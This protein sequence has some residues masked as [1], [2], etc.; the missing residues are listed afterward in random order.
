[1]KLPWWAYRLKLRLKWLLVRRSE[2]INQITEVEIYLLDCS[3]GK[4]PQPTRAVC[5]ILSLRLGTPK[6]YWSEY[7]KDAALAAAEAPQ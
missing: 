6:Q 4:K 2:L 7:I 5:R 1:M 3:R